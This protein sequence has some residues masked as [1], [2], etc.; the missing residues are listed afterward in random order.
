MRNPKTTN[1][2]YNTEQTSLPLPLLEETPVSKKTEAFEVEIE[3]EIY[4]NRNSFSKTDHKAVL[5]PV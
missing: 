2:K 3:V 4:E 5:F 1:K